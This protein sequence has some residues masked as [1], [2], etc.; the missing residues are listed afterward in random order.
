MASFRV[1]SAFSCQ[2]LVSWQNI[3]NLTHGLAMG[4]VLVSVV[5]S[6]A[7]DN[8]LTPA[9]IAE[10]AS[11]IPDQAKMT[12]FAKQ[13]PVIFVTRDPRKPEVWANLK[14]FWNTGKAEA[15]DPATGD[16]VTRDVVFIKV[17]LGLN[18]APPVPTENPLTA[19]KVMLGKKLYFDTVISSNGKVSCA[20]C[21]NPALGFTDQLKTSTGIFDQ[22]GGMNAPT[23]YNSGYHLLQFWNGRAPTLEHQAQGPPQ[24][25]LEMH[26]GKGNPWYQVVSRL[27]KNP[28]YVEAFAKVFGTL[29]TRDGA[30]KAIA[31]YERLV[32]TGN[33]IVDR[34]ELAM[35]TR[36]EEEGEGKLET[37]AADFTK[38]LKDAL[39]SKDTEALEA[40]GLEASS[41]SGKISEVAASIQR[42]KV[43]F[44]NKARCNSCHVGDNYSD[45][46]FHNLG[47]GAKDGA[48]PEGADLGRFGAQET[49]HKDASLIG[50]YKT[51]GLR[52]LLSTA[53]YMH[54]GSEATL[55]AVVDLYNKGGNLNPHLSNKM[56]DEPSERDAAKNGQKA[57]I[58][59]KLLLTT[60]EKKDLVNFMK[61]LQGESSAEIIAKP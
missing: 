1:L 7:A 28:E 22:K 5:K 10:S 6:T 45:S 57:V 35:R 26:D 53:P 32:L 59:R 52:Q 11:G 60:D 9:Q 50:A 21:H 3:A 24:N 48:W 2:N 34:A 47:I 30:A 27:R 58:P 43:L 12:P 46:Q 16:K 8:D 61:A 51:P 40:L 13:V 4:L 31:A 19:E 15:V 36:V 56:R 38:V 42:G 33:S 20:S 49:G 23:V 37:N 25:P 41:N 18:S 29:P 54:D 44:S 39:A 17:P 14:Q 55:E